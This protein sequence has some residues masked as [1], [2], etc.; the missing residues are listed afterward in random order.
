MRATVSGVALERRAE[1]EALFT[2]FRYWRDEGESAE[3]TGTLAAGRL[4]R[5]GGLAAEECFFQGFSVRRPE[6]N[7]NEGSYVGDPLFVQF[8][9][10]KSLDR[11]LFNQNVE[12][13][14]LEQMGRVYEAVALALR[15]VHLNPEKEP[16]APPNKKQRKRPKRRQAEERQQEEERQGKLPQQVPE[17]Q[18][19]PRNAQQ[20]PPERHPPQP[21]ERQGR[22][23]PQQPKN[24]PNWRDRREESVEYEP[25]PKEPIYGR[26]NWKL[27]AQ[28]S[29]AAKLG[30]QQ[31]PKNNFDE[32]VQKMPETDAKPPKKKLKL[33][34]FSSANEGF[35]P[36]LNQMIGAKLK[37]AAAKQPP[38][39]YVY[40]PYMVPVV[41]MVPTAPQQPFY[42]YPPMYM[43]PPN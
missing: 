29:Q 27:H 26:G 22:P 25:A 37:S 8:C 30:K 20:Q 36:G 34:S 28:R 5:E 24:P 32:Y 15:S 40:V 14:S 1:V 19:Q 11:D 21:L 10:Q 38:P 13:T 35:V 41:P 2:G 43:Y 17:R 4:P 9:A 7:A 39:E 23:V 18:P 3:C 33:N 16:W 12:K 6:A 31:P 42:G